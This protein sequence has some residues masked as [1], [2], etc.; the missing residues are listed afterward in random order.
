MDVRL[1]D[2]PDFRL[3]MGRASAVAVFWKQVALAD[4]VIVSKGD[5][6]DEEAAGDVEHVVASA[7]P[8][9]EVVFDR[10][11]AADDWLPVPSVGGH[12]HHA[13][14]GARHNGIVLCGA[15]EAKK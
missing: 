14:T 1:E 11:F 7:N 4:Y 9:A 12:R 5:L 2:F 15:T 8:L 3:R 6:V 13:P 10:A